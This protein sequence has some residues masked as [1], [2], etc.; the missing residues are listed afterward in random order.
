MDALEL[1]MRAVD[2]VHPLLS[3]LSLS[4]GKLGGILPPEYQGREKVREWVSRLERM[5]AA[6][7]L[8][9]EEARQLK[10]DLESSH[11]GFHSALPKSG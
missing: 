1:S 3:D 9:E 4:L 6:D 11:K 2:Q 5:G 8:N 10:F 7:E